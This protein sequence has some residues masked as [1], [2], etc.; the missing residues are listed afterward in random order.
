MTT[1]SCNPPAL[2]WPTTAAGMCAPSPEGLRPWV[3]ER[4]RC[5]IVPAAAPALPKLIVQASA[6]QDTQAGVQQL[7]KQVHARFARRCRGGAAAA[8]VPGRAAGAGAVPPTYTLLLRCDLQAAVQCGGCWG[9]E[10]CWGSAGLAPTEPPACEHRQRQWPGGVSTIA[11][12]LRERPA[13][14]SHARLPPH[15]TQPAG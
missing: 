12:P 5:S 7:S 4:R 2:H 14:S 6:A 1:P 9:H 8:A 13:P 10:R 3:C 11:R 15:A